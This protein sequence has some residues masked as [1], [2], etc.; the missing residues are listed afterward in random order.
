MRFWSLIIA[1]AT[2]VAKSK[3]NNTI[4]FGTAGGVTANSV[5]VA[6][7]AGFTRIDTAMEQTQWYNSEQVSTG[8]HRFCLEQHSQKLNQS[9][10]SCLS[11]IKVTTKVPPWLFDGDPN[12]IR[13]SVDQELSIL[14]PSSNPSSSPS[15]ID[16]ILLHAPHC[17]RGWHQFCDSPLYSNVTHDWRSAWRGLEK[18]VHVDGSVDHIGVSNFDLPLL[19]ELVDWVQTRQKNND[20]FAT[21]PSTLQNSFSPLDTSH[22]PIPLREFCAHHDIRVEGY[23]MLS[24]LSNLISANILSPL[25]ILS[26]ALNQN[27]SIIPRSNNTT[28]IIDLS[29]II[30]N[31]PIHLSSEKI[32]F[33]ETLSN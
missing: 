10:A 8:L 25:E 27:I 9:F 31:G 22:L 11:S 15:K 16:T 17:W 18:A 6:L 29:I 24:P 14:Y 2:T 28:N 20:K 7:S 19:T 26:Y 5:Y 32:S 33:I 4:S 21:F 30:H 3:S 23:S 12:T 1:V 13:S